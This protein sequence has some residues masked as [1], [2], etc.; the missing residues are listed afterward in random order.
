MT[1]SSNSSSNNIIRRSLLGQ[2][3]RDNATTSRSLLGQQPRDNTTTS[4]FFGYKLLASDSNVAYNLIDTQRAVLTRWFRLPFTLLS[5][6][7]VYLYD[8]L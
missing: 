3:P 7:R 2:Q 1:R 8:T 5:R 6:L 4:S